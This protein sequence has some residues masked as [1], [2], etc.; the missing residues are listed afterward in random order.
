MAGK[1]RWRYVAE[2][3]QADSYGILDPATGRFNDARLYGGKPPNQLNGALE[4]VKRLGA[5]ASSPLWHRGQLIVADD[6][7][8]GP[9][10]VGRI[11]DPPCVRSRGA[12]GSPYSG[13]S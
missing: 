4:H 7:P 9:R 10:R 6:G 12:S 3:A 5:F 1:L 8:S 11:I 13:R 2:A